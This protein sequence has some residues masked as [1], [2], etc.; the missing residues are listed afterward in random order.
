[1]CKDGFV[2][3]ADTE[4]TVGS[5][6]VQGSKIADY[7]GE[8]SHFYSVVIGGA[9]DVNYIRMASQNI[10]DG[11]AG[12]PEPTVVNIKGE[13]KKVI[14]KVHRNDIYRYW[15]PS[16]E[17]CPGCDLVIGIEDENHDIRVLLTDGP[18]ISEVDACAITGSGSELAEHLVE[19]M[20]VRGMSA[21]VTANLA[22]Q[23]LREVKNKAIHVG[24][25]TEIIARRCNKQN[26]TAEPFFDIVEDDR[27]F[28]WGLEDELFSGIRNGLE[29]SEN[30]LKRR[31]DL[32]VSRLASL[33]NNRKE[34]DDG[35][36]QIHIT[37]FGT[38]YGNWFKDF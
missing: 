35:A 13:V 11:V 10:R 14:D 25:N 4:M 19:K 33:S 37:E 9:G 3:A 32:I 23:I 31:S 28:L 36:T 26:L 21:A 24:G 30:A 8:G 20:W 27:R 22:L 29:R 34:R 6:I 12:L 17:H 15:E 5:I 18:S 1:M 16:E 2:I 7:S 38:E